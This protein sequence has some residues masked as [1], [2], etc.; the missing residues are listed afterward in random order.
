MLT[1]EM[2]DTIRA[3]VQKYMAIRAGEEGPPNVYFRA[4]YGKALTKAN[5]AFT[6][7][8]PKHFED[9]AELVNEVF[10]HVSKTWAAAEEPQ[11]LFLCVHVVGDN[12]PL[13]GLTL[14][15]EH[16]TPW[17]DAESAFL[18]RKGNLASNSGAM[19][20]AAAIALLDVVHTFKE[21]TISTQTQN[22][23]LV[24]KCVEFGVR[25][26]ISEER[27][28]LLLQEHTEARLERMMDRLDPH[29]ERWAPALINAAG[30]LAGAWATKDVAAVPPVDHEKA[31]DWYIDRFGQSMFAM[32][33]FFA[34]SPE[35][36]TKEREA[37]IGELLAR[38]MAAAQSVK[39]Q[40]A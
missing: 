10:D 32:G 13:D 6:G 28:A 11:R 31:A 29:L 18:A 27:S 2:R 21:M 8:Y 23:E 7:I 35:K 19:E 37:R 3:F 17:Q 20:Q 26:Q 1:P 14:H 5:G 25:A 40:Q 33:T 4:K 9:T 30:S 22:R 16:G 39:E 24:D 38:M 12:N 36:L 15:F 34:G